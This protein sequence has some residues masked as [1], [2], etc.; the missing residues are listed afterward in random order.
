MGGQI[1][2]LKPEIIKRMGRKKYPDQLPF[3]VKLFNLC[4]FRYFG[5]FR[6]R[7]DQ[8]WIIAEKVP[9]GVIL[10]AW[11]LLPYLI[12]L[13]MKVTPLISVAKNW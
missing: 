4:P 2:Y 5:D 13:S 9:L 1:F 11:I 7:I 12:R 3:P 8:S 10:S 6:F